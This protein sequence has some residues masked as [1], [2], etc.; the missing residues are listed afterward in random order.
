MAIELLPDF[1]R[2]N[3]EVQEWK[4]ATA[5]LYHDFPAEW[6][7]IIDVLTNFRL[8]QSQIESPGGRK[9]PVADALDSAFYARG[10]TE[11]SF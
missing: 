4:H 7:D 1:V 10:W 5:I 6:Q 9:S 11:K 2:T 8:R 3:Y